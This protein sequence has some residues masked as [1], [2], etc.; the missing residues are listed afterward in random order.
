MPLQTCGLESSKSRRLDCRLRNSVKGP[1]LC[2][3]QC[4]VLR[5]HEIPM[6]YAD[7]ILER[8]CGV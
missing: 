2:A 5:I 8:H 7:I 4:Y 3:V 6:E 1:E